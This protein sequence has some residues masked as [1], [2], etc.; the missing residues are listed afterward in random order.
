MESAIPQHLRCPRTRTP[1]A[2]EDYVPPYPAWVARMKHGVKQVVMAYF[3]V[4]YRGDS[5]RAKALQFVAS[6]RQDFVLPDGPG[7]HDLAH[8]VDEAGFDNLIAVA[9]W[10]AEAPFQRWLA[11]PL[12][13][14]WWNDPARAMDE[15]GYF[16]EIVFPRAEHFETLFSTPDRFEGVA[17]LAAGLS[18]DIQEHGYWGS[19]RDRLPISQTDALRTSGDIRIQKVAEPGRRV[20]VTPHENLTLIR[21]GQEWTETE[22][23]ER[24]IYLKEVEPIFREGMHFL[25]DDGQAEGCYANRYMYH[26]D[27]QL[28]PLQKSF[29]MSYW[30]SL[31]HL[32]RWAESHSTHL[33]IFGSFMGM[34]QAMNFE[35]KLRLYHE[36]T[37]VSA[38]EQFYEYVNCHPRTGLLRAG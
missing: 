13:V 11:T 17:R 4:Q 34:V 10:D 8:Y 36:V 25:R 24:D 26:V 1:R 9:Y 21:S 37:V 3:G 30:R 29:G 31:E 12:V 35:L 2:S 28:R 23:R 15:V 7:H 32:E 14:T 20:R 38:D 6:L 18:D 22:G 19:A 33:A 16:R 27:E 5:G